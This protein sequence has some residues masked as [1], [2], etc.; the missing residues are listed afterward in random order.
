MK[1]S[2]FWKFVF[3]EILTTLGFI[4]FAYWIYREIAE[5][6]GN[7]Y[8]FTG[9][10]VK[11]TPVGVAVLGFGLLVACLVGIYINYKSKSEERDFIKKY[12]HRIKNNENKTHKK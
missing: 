10:G 12:G 3:A 7:E 9:F 11:F 5:G 6:R 2:F 1:K 4:G 8:Y